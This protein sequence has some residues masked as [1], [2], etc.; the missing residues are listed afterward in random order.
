M[1]WNEIEEIQAPAY[2]TD[3]ITRILAITNPEMKST[4]AFARTVIDQ[5][6]ISAIYDENFTKTKFQDAAD[7]QPQSQQEDPALLNLQHETQILRKVKFEGEDRL[8]SGFADYTLWY[9]ARKS[10]LATNLIIVEAKKLGG[11][12]ECLPQLT[13][14]MGAVHDI[15]KEEGKTNSTVFGAAADGNVFR[16]CRIDNDGRW[17]QSPLLEWEQGQESQIYSMFRTLVRIAAL[18]FPSTSPIKDPK[19]RQRVIAEFGTPSHSKSYDFGLK[20]LE[21]LEEGSDVEIVELPSSKK[22]KDSA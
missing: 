6:L 20:G 18:S 19:K 7:S 12:D 9:D 1:F 4:E 10:T 5:I 22:G 16:F 14:Y 21:I 17:S 8:L 15:R 13:A 2:L 3:N 11:T